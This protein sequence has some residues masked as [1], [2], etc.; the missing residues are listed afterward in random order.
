MWLTESQFKNGEV[1][2][3]LRT[4]R[5]EIVE[6]FPLHEEKAP[7]V[8]AEPPSPSEPPPAAELAPVVEPP[9]V[10]EDPVEE[11][12]EPEAPVVYSKEDLDN[13]NYREELQPLLSTLGLSARGSKNDLVD[14]VLE[15]Q[16]ALSGE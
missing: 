6:G 10:V 14:R 4:K 12:P 3:L 1:Q 13:M 16:G 2:E 8:E 9:P 11:T 7:V 15:H 5:L